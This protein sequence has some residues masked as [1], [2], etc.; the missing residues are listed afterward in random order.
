MARVGRWRGHTKALRQCKLMYQ[1]RLALSD[2]QAKKKEK[3]H[4]KEVVGK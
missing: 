3:G 1:K 2:V 4:G